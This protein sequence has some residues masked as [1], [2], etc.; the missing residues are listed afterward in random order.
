MNFWASV[1]G[2]VLRGRPS[3]EVAQPGA[4]TEGRPYKSIPDQQKR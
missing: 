4:A 3:V 1:V 2:A